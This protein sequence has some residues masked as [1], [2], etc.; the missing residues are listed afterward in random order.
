MAW[1]QQPSG[2]LSHQRSLLKAIAALGSLQS[3]QEAS[4]GEAD[5]AQNAV[6]GAV[7]HLLQT[8]VCMMIIQ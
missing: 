1:S 4:G 8:E 7:R 5:G 6:G 2:L 3:A